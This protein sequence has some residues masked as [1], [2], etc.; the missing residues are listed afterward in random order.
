[1]N[2]GQFATQFL[3][4]LVTVTLPGVGWLIKNRRPR[5]V[6]AAADL[7]AAAEAR[8]TDAEAAAIIARSDIE[9]VQARQKQQGELI[10][11][12][13][14]QIRETR[15]LASDAEGRVRAAERRADRAERRIDVLE[16]TLRASNIP[17]PATEN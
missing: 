12:L 11:D 4:A 17:V 5:A 9:G 16:R 6:K 7:R 2:V 3:I 14:K 13:Y 1:M 8:K 15:A 10:D